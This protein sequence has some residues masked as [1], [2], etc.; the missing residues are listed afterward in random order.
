MH[1][2]DIMI[3]WE[4]RERQCPQASTHDT[5]LA[6]VPK[7]LSQ[8][9]RPFVPPTPSAV[10]VK[11]RIGRV[12][13]PIRRCPPERHYGNKRNKGY[14]SIDGGNR[15][16]NKKRRGAYISISS[17]NCPS[18]HRNSLLRSRATKCFLHVQSYP[19]PGPTLSLSFAS[20]C[21]E[22]PSIT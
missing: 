22:F 15:D 1:F 4:A 18:S 10:P 20:L 21:V 19:T 6:R 2:I 9:P 8:F 14:S 12:T 3:Q 11:P 17:P 7:S 16:G 5:R 13:Q